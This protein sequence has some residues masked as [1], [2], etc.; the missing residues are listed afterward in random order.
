MHVRRAGYE[1]TGLHVIGRA[2][3]DAVRAA[4]AHADGTVLYSD[5]DH[6]VRWAE[7]A[8]DELAAAVAAAGAHDVT[9]FGRTEAVIRALPGPL[10]AT[11][12]IINRVFTEVTGHDWDLLSGVR[13]LSRAAIDEIV[14]TDVE[15]TAAN[16]V[17]WVYRALVADLDVVYVEAD[18][19]DYED[20][21][22]F[23]RLDHDDTFRRRVESEPANW[24]TRLQVAEHMV[25]ALVRLS[26]VPRNPAGDGLTDR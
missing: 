10:R 16:D 22:Q 12:T 18:G 8:P 9:V 4:A 20:Q 13:A 1:E 3:R 2:R 23:G 14:A 11:E 25:A 21:E 17:T 19:L 6:I 24:L 7:H 26:S 5:I 15:D